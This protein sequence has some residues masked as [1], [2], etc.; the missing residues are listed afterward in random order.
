MAAL[1]VTPGGQKKGF[2]AAMISSLLGDLVTALVMLHFVLWSGANTAGTGA[3]I[4]LLCWLGFFA[5]IQ[6]PQSL[7]EQR[8]LKVFAINAGYWLVGM[9]GSGALLAVWR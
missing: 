8:P 2:A 9:L 3:F 4:G 7:Y 5:A 1:G 6:L